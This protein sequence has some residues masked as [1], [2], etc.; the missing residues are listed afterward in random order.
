MAASHREVRILSNLE[1]LESL[2]K[3]KMGMKSLHNGELKL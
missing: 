2:L 1:S 3:R